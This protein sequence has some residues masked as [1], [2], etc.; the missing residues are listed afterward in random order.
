MFQRRER[1]KI[2]HS[3][4]YNKVKEAA[5][6]LS[7]VSTFCCKHAIGGILAL[8]GLCLASCGAENSISRRYPCQFI[9]K[10]INHPGTSIETA[11]NNQGT[12]A[13]VSTKQVKGVWHIYSILNDGKNKVD[14]YTLS[15]LT[16]NY[17]NY[18]YIGAGNDT[19]DATKNGFILGLT[20]FNGPIAWDRQCPNCITQYG[21]TNFPLEWTG[22]RQ[23]VVCKKCNRTYALETGAI[24]DGNKGD[25]L[26][27][28]N[29]TYNGIGSVLTVGN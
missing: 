29:V 5:D 11:L 19:K 8:T 17:A 9:F 24:T 10:T 1:M 26:M 13:F 27:K 2:K 12:Y 18:S 4:I 23:S 25:A 20:N 7:A 15:T 14:D 6:H 3:Y 28:Y 22:N 16:E 21:S